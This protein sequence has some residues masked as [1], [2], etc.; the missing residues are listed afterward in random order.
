MPTTRYLAHLGSH[1][2]VEVDDLVQFPFSFGDSH[3]EAEALPVV[4][5]IIDL[6]ARGMILL[7]FPADQPVGSITVSPDGI[8]LVF[9][10]PCFLRERPPIGPVEHLIR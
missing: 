2:A 8:G 4:G 9:M 10:D 6:N 7:A 3:G 5:R 1:I